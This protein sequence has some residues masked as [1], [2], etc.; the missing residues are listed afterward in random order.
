MSAQ[1]L[2]H[3]R[4]PGIR[5]VVLAGREHTDTGKVVIGCAHLRPPVHEFSADH[6]LLQ[7]A[8]LEPR[9]AHPRPLLA[10]MAGAFWGWT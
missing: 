9:T 5:T 3:G 10:R 6:E 8:L 4:A 1:V 2:S 7:A